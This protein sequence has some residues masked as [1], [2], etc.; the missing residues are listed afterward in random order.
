MVSDAHE[1]I[2]SAVMDPS[3][4]GAFVTGGVG[5][6][7]TWLGRE[8]V[9][10]LQGSHELV[11]LAAQTLLADSPFGVLAMF[12][13]ETEI[14]AAASSLDMVQIIHEELLNRSAVSGKVPLIVVDNAQW[15]D[16]DSCAVLEQLAV[17]GTVGMLVLCRPGNSHMAMSAIFE[18]DTLLAQHRLEP[19]TGEQVLQTCETRLGGTIVPGAAAVLAQ[20]SGG[21]PLFLHGFID[22]AL[23]LG[24]LVESRSVW[25]LTSA[26]AEPAPQLVDMAVDVWREFSDI[27]QEILETVALAEPL[28]AAVLNRLFPS[29]AYAGLVEGHILCA[30]GQSDSSVRFVSPVFAR[31]LQQ[32]VPVGRSARIKSRVME[33]RASR[34]S[35]SWTLMRHAGW[36][37][38]CGQHVSDR[39]L[40]HAARIANLRSKPRLALRLA[41]AVASQP[42]A[43][44]ARHQAVLA[45]SELQQFDHGRAMAEQLVKEAQEL[46]EY[47]AAA[48][49]VV[50]L[51]VLEGASSAVLEDIAVEWR[52]FYASV[53]ITVCA[54]ADLVDSLVRVALGKALSPDRHQQLVQTSASGEYVELQIAGTALLAQVQALVG[55]HEGACRDFNRALG[56]LENH[57][58]SLNALRGV[59]QGQYVMFLSV[60]GDHPRALETVKEILSSRGSD[61][62]VRLGGLPELVRAL[63]ALAAGTVAKAVAEFEVAVVALRESDPLFALPFAL[64]AAAYAC[65]LLQDQQRAS[66]FV[67]EFNS[68][69]VNESVPQWL[70]AKAY[71]VVAGASQKGDTAVFGL[72]HALAEKA[73]RNG[74]N[75]TE[76]AILNVSLRAGCIDGLERMGGVDAPALGPATA[77]IQGIALGLLAADPEALEEIA[78]LPQAGQN[79]LLCAESLS[80]ALRLHTQMGNQPGRM[81]VLVLLR[82]MEFPFEAMGSIAIAELAAA[83]E[84]TA[85]GKELAWLGNARC[86]NKDIAEKFTLSQRTVEGHI[87]KIYSK[88]GVSNREELYASWLPPL[89]NS[90]A[91]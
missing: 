4:G 33:A 16:Q 7:K 62:T 42:Q 14:S 83:A 60:S 20:L 6:G 66:A 51:A 89:L 86:T 68:S 85:R 77:M 70:L 58:G 61:V 44:G 39:L 65:H 25:A 84:L 78:A 36:S 55:N 76:L 30:G 90:P 23:K 91:K 31:S 56:L 11:W 19:L 54:G 79:R 57:S 69:N 87:Y 13:P 82:E 45:H 1:R 17:S 50:V 28:T 29:S 43:V 15:V 73:R 24:I 64:A 35:S 10:E 72:L 75:A 80:Y 67:D 49:L 32:R 71:I 26:P 34:P 2:L 5:M 52:A 41:A 9:T 3:I 48:T 59:L 37:L 21:H 8:I 12:L 74:A 38:D 88:L 53:G 40:L 63:A 22:A 18:D 27:E 81:R 47:D 46:A